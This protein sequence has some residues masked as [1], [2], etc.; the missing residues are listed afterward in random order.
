MYLKILPKLRCLVAFQNRPSA[1]IGHDEKFVYFTFLEGQFYKEKP[2]LVDL[3]KTKHSF[4]VFF[5]ICFRGAFLTLKY[6]TLVLLSYFEKIAH[7]S[8]V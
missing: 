5:P 1:P 7:M 4:E 3:K 2:S 6:E 8:V